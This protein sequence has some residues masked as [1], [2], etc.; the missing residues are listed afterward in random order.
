MR[1]L[2][3]LAGSGEQFPRLCLRLLAL[4]LARPSL[5]HDELRHLCHPQLGPDE[6]P[7]E[8]TAQFEQARAAVL[9]GEVSEPDFD[10]LF[11]PQVRRLATHRTLSD[12]Q[13]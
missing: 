13:H 4:L 7:P 1:R 11:A 9:L 8:W 6:A 12:E 5:W 3:E 2:Q 10:A